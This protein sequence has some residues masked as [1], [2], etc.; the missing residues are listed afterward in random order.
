MRNSFLTQSHQAHSFFL[1]TLCADFTCFLLPFQVSQHS[2]QLPARWVSTVDE[3]LLRK[4]GT[5]SLGFT[6]EEGKCSEAVIRCWDFNGK[7]V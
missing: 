5:V 1:G 7:W 6:E 3:T 2:S 4:T